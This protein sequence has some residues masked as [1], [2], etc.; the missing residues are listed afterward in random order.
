MHKYTQLLSKAKGIKKELDLMREQL[1]CELRE[2]NELSLEEIYEILDESGLAITKDGIP[3]IYLNTEDVLEEYTN[4]CMRYERVYLDYYV[5]F[6]HTITVY[7]KEDS[8]SVKVN[9]PYKILDEKEAE[10]L[11]RE[12]V[13]ELYIS[14]DPEDDEVCVS[15]NEEWDKQVICGIDLPELRRFDGMIIYKGDDVFEKVISHLINWRES[16]G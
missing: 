11:F 12:Q 8:I 1:L 3:H 5:E 2:A 6:L 16:C 7:Y 10:K 15:Y 9:S 14:I 13:T 4:E